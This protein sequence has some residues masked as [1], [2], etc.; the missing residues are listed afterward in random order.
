MASHKTTSEFINNE[1]PKGVP[2][3]YNIAT[4]SNNSSSLTVGTYERAKAS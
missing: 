3:A 4:G 2:D 1:L